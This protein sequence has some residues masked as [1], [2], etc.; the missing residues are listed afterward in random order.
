MR[1]AAYLARKTYTPMPWFLN[2]PLTELVLVIADLEG[3]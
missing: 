2:L 1:W 3:E